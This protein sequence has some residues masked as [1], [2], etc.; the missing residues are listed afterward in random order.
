[1]HPL[2]FMLGYLMAKDLPENRDKILAG[3]TA[4]QFP[5]H[6]LMGPVLLKP[7]MIDK[8]KE[9]DQTKKRVKAFEDANSQLAQD[10]CQKDPKKFNKIDFEKLSTGDAEKVKGFLKSIFQIT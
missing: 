7:I 1:M 5:T 8:A 2:H 3:L 6:N 10:L 9:L 4:A